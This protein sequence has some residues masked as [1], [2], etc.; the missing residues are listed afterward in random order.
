M[1]VRQR[2]LPVV[3]ALCLGPSVTAQHPRA[4]QP[5]SRGLLVRH[6]RVFDPIS[7]TFSDTLDI[8][9]RGDRIS[10][11]GRLGPPGQGMAHLDAGG[12][13]ALPGL[14]DSHVHFSFLTLGGDT[15]VTTTLAAFVRHGV[16]SVR[17]VGGQLDT[18]AGLTRRVASGRTLGPRIYFAGPLLSRAPMLLADQNNLLPG[19]AVA[20]ET[21]AAVDSMLDRLVA[22]GARMTKAIDRWDPTLFRYYLR[23]ARAR[24]LRVVWDAGLPIFNRIPIDTALAL[25]VTSIE[26]AKAVWSGVLRDDLARQYDS[27]MAIDDTAA[28]PKALLQ[29]WMALGEQSVSRERLA[30]LADTWANSGAYFCP[31][32]QQAVDNLAGTPPEGYQRAFAGLLEVSWLFVR[33]LAAHGVKMLVG[34]DNVEPDGTLREMDLLASAGVSPVEILRGATIYPARWLGVDSIVGTLEPGRRAD[35]LILDANPLERI[36]NIRSAWA[37]VHDGKIAFGPQE[38]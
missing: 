31:T 2:L 3:L 33:E 19:M 36:T 1:S 35:I 18:I 32:L 29:R 30:A 7:G 23:A 28:S 21:P 16:T 27:V 9:I 11:V 38:R 24:S 6:V 10:A 5:D 37:V 15:T 12:K 22:R 25:G 14:W 4:A 20:V 13:Y 8:L 26:H 17:D 34:Q